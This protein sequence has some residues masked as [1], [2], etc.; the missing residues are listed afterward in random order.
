[1]ALYI[2]GL[3][4]GVSKRSDMKTREGR[5]F[6]DRPVYQILLTESAGHIGYRSSIVNITMHH[7]QDHQLL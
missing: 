5:I 7:K 3:F 6:E 2:E 1:M 4:L